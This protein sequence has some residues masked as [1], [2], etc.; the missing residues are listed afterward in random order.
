MTDSP[1]SL[2]V[3]AAASPDDPEAMDALEVVLADDVVAAG[4]FVNA[5]GRAAVLQALASQAMPAMGFATWSDPTET[6]G[7]TVVRGELPPGFPIGAIA[8]R[9]RIVDGRLAEAV[10]LVEMPAP[11]PVTDVHLDGEVAGAINGAFD[12][13]APM[14]IAYVDEQSAP[15]VSFRGTV[16]VHDSRTLALWIRDPNGG[17]LRAIETNPHVSLIYR[18]PETRLQ[19]DI[20]GRAH[21]DDDSAIRDAVF[22]ASPPFEQSLDAARRGAAVLIDVDTVRGGTGGTVVN[23]DRGVEA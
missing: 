18:H 6:D 9:G 2:F 17:L 21:R 10:Q 23:M 15:H 16:H 14:V 11:P 12:A 3:A 1:V 22:A 4:P 19:Y 7:F 13:R 20:T 8:V 5:T